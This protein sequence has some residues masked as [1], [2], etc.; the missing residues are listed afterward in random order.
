MLFPCELFINLINVNTKQYFFV[1]QLPVVIINES[2][3][4]LSFTTEENIDFKDY[5]GFLIYGRYF[6]SES[7]DLLKNSDVPSDDSKSNN[8][9]SNIVLK[10][11]L[12]VII[13]VLIIGIIVL[14]F[15]V[16]RHKLKKKKNILNDDEHGLY[17]N[18]NNS[19]HFSHYTASDF[20]SDEVLNNS[21]D[22]DNTH[23][24]LL[25][26]VNKTATPIIS[27]KL[28]RKPN[29]H[30]TSDSP[31]GSDANISLIPYDNNNK[32]MIQKELD[33]GVDFFDKSDLVEVVSC[34]YPYN[35]A[36][37]EKNKNILTMI[38]NHFLN[39]EY[40]PDKLYDVIRSSLSLGFFF[41]CVRIYFLFSNYI[42]FLIYSY[43]N[44]QY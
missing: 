12:S 39:N 44:K 38:A 11:L 7:F 25:D 5:K 41:L 23:K 4:S 19:P 1:D 43:C 14:I 27:S 31:V 34:D 6:Y 21:F 36:L 17:L 2:Y 3:G 18:L 40:I 30:A 32:Q 8:N 29:L 13:S 42:L 22:N 10:V 33:I 35:T 16:V 20:D 15:F 28:N 37:A 26:E 9:T 24:T